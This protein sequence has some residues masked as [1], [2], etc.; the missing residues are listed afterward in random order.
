MFE[1]FRWNP[2][3]IGTT[4]TVVRNEFERW[5]RD[6]G[7]M[8]LFNT[9]PENKMGEHITAVPGFERVRDYRPTDPLTGRQ[10]AR[11]WQGVELIPR[12]ER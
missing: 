11:R 1:C 5:C 12:D 10:G 3:T 4:K 7:C 8:E 9:L 6:N 2:E